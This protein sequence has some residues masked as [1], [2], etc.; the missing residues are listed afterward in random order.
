M[1]SNEKV[2]EKRRFRDACEAGG[3]GTGQRLRGEGG[4][5]GGEKLENKRNTAGYLSR[6]SQRQ[7]CG[8]EKVSLI[9]RGRQRGPNTA[10]RASAST[11]S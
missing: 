2:G 7:D 10:A 8:K 4:G 5:E 11:T 9:V 3:E 6:Q 1:L